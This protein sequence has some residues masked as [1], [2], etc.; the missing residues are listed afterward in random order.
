LADARGGLSMS[1]WSS[2][3][4]FHYWKRGG[5]INLITLVTHVGEIVLQVAAET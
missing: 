4:S 3:T 1:R 2:T 5:H